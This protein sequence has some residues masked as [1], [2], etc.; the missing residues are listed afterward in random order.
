MAD[1]AALRAAFDIVIDTYNSYYDN[2]GDIVTEIFNALHTYLNVLTA[3]A[4]LGALELCVDR[5]CSECETTLQ[6]TGL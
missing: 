4:C 3:D 6:L 1:S 2:N 5:I